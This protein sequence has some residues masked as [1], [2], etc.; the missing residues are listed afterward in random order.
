VSLTVLLYAGRYLERAWSS[1]EYAKFLVACT[2]GPNLQA[3]A[4]C[5]LGSYLLNSPGLLY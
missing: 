4:V 3:F 1:K 2:V 5:V